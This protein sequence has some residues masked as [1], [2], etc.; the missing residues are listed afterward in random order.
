MK[1]LFKP[2]LLLITLYVFVADIEVKASHIMGGEMTYEYIGFNSI[3]GMEQYRICVF[4]YRDDRGINCP[5][6]VPIRIYEDDDGNPLNF[7]NLP[8]IAGSPITIT[9]S[10]SIWPPTIPA[11]CIPPLTPLPYAVELCEYC[12]II[13]LP[14]SLKGYH[15]TTGNC[16]RN[17][18]LENLVP[19]SGTWYAFIPPTYYQNSSPSFTDIATPF[20]CLCDTTTVFNTATDVDGDLLIFSFSNPLNQAPGANIVIP[21]D[22]ALYVPP[23]NIEYPFGPNGYID[24]N[25]STGLTTFMACDPGLCTPEC[26]YVVAVEVREYRNGILI[27]IIKREIQFVVITCPP[28]APPNPVQVGGCGQNVYNIEEGDSLCFCVEGIDPD[29]DSVFIASNGF[30]F[31]SLIVNPPATLPDVQ[32]DSIAS[33][34]FCWKT[35]CGQA[36]AV[37]YLFNVALSDNGCPPKATNIVYTINVLPYQGISQILGIDTLCANETANYTV[38]A[39]AG[40]SLYSWDIVGGTI[41]TD[42]TSNTVTVQWADTTGGLLSVSEITGCNNDTIRL[43]VKL[44]IV[45][46]DAGINEVICLG[47]SIQLSASGGLAYAWSYDSTLSD[48]GIADPWAKPVVTTT[49]TVFVTDSIGCIGLDF[50]IIFVNPPININANNIG[51]CLG[52]SAVLTVTD[53][54]G[55]TYWWMV[56]LPPLDTILTDTTS[57]GGI[58]SS[59]ITVNPSDTTDYYITAFNGACYNTDTI[60]VNVNVPALGPNT[61]I[62]FGDTTTLN[63]SGGNFFSW[64]SSTTLSDTSI[65]A[66]LAYPDTTTTYTVIIGTVGGGC[67]DTL[68]V[69]LTVNLLPEADAQGDVKICFGDSIQL[70]GT[71]A[72]TG[73]AYNWSP[74]VFLDNCTIA[75]PVAFPDSNT[76][77][78]LTVTD[79]NGCID[80][81][82]MVL[83]VNP[84]LTITVNPASICEGDSAVLTIT[85]AQFYTWKICGDTNT[86]STD[87][88]I[89]VSPP[90]TAYY[91]VTASDGLCARDTTVTVN[92]NTMPTAEAGVNDSICKF[93]STAL[94]ASGGTTF[95]WSPV[96]GLSC[97]NCSDPIANPLATTTY[98]V[99][100]G[101]G[102]NCF[103]F[104]SVTIVVFGGLS[105]SINGSTDAVDSVTC[106]GIC[107]GSALVDAIGSDEP[108]TYSWDNGET[109]PLVDSLCSG[110]YTVTVTDT[111]NCSSA[112]TITFFEK[113]KLTASII[114]I[115]NIPCFGG[116]TGSASIVVSG[117]NPQYSY[118][119]KDLS[120][121]IIDITSTVSDFKAGIYF[122]TVTDSLGCF[123]QD[124][125]EITQPAAPLSDTN[126]S[127]YASCTGAEDG[128]ITVKVNGG[129]KPYNYFLY[130]FS[131]Q[132]DTNTITIGKLMAGMYIDT[133]RDANGCMIIDTV[134]VDVDPLGECHV[135]V[136]NAFT[137]DGDGMNDIL[138]VRGRNIVKVKF[139]IYNRWGE[140]V[141][142]YESNNPPT[143]GQDGSIVGEGWDG[144]KKG[145][146]LNSAVFFYY[147]DVKFTNENEKFLKGDV[148]LI[149]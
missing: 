17:S 132:T 10:G 82:S 27:G 96:T 61:A 95:T 26:L 3:T 54:V 2:I 74:C 84:V 67:F 33:T 108:F 133:V 65:A 45:P 110:V 145:K 73:G 123:V 75:T 30:I 51:I 122:V 63:A 83:T 46:A 32:G 71:G 146:K 141:F 89:T 21:L 1:N 102:N 58:D 148:T 59:S 98:Y 107:D 6:S 23:F 118:Q 9:Q 31:D 149:R 100:V 117:G 124:S 22:T 143:G 103:D 29:G 5:G 72:G 101:L 105:S 7:V 126:S 57:G 88:T 76:E 129:T 28:Q 99:T 56:N 138:Y 131:V 97:T 47:D 35:S 38:D 50:V 106:N 104:D 34:T 139:T 90:D 130:P 19:N 49:Y 94:S 147:L 77:F 37:P 91:C 43:A 42:S 78:I 112:S 93:D 39:L 64:Y 13:E 25:A 48:T 41:L 81:D 4:F 111:N 140:K 119:W 116:D 79:S 36:S 114:N 137:P 14:P 24:I 11:Q 53:S 44:N 80:S 70:L 18:D 62:C 68:D 69:T 135:W 16:C 86:I 60:T 15:I 85:G 40:G 55:Y 125:I 109:T 142:E 113:I 66:P 20:L 52:D 12:A 144:K 134:W 8:Q 136:P 128:S 121:A 120:G 127:T 92:V 87:S 115:T